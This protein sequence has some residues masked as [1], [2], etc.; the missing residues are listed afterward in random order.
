MPFDYGDAEQGHAD[1][2]FDENE[3]TEEED[4]PQEHT[5]VKFQS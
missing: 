3:T 1:A 5:L 4:L 2:D